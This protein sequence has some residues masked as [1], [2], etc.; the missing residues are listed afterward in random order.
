[1][2][3]ME[4]TSRLA[5]GE[6]LE[7]VK[8]FFGKGGQGLEL[9]EESASCLT[10]TGGGGYVTATVCRGGERDESRYGFPGMGISG[11]RISCQAFLRFAPQSAQRNSLF[12][13][14]FG[15]RNILG[16]FYIWISARSAF[17]A[18]NRWSKD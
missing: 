15:E 17:S 3:H 6:V 5:P 16:H 7:R 4:A 11:Q 12:E 10:F 2:I 1:M 18:V 14:N 13:E 8:K 9:T